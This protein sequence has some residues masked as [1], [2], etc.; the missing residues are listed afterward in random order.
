LDQSAS[1]EKTQPRDRHGSMY[2]CL[3]PEA[4]LGNGGQAG[5]VLVAQGDVEGQVLDRGAPRLARRSA[6]RTPTTLP[7]SRIA[8]TLPCRLDLGGLDFLSLFLSLLLSLLIPLCTPASC[9]DF[10]VL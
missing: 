8:A 6:S 5:A 9:T 1:G 4:Q 2:K 10:R 7:A 3:A